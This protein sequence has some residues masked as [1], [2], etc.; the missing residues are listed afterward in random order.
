[1]TKV[2]EYLLLQNKKG[3]LPLLFCYAPGED[4]TRDFCVSSVHNVEFIPLLY[5][6]TI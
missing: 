2:F 1:M 5:I 6:C 3:Q 4:R